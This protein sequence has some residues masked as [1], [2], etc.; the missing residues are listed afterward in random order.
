[1]TVD[2]SSIL[3]E[4]GKKIDI[5]CNIYPNE[6]EFLGGKYEFTSPIAVSGSIRNNGES[7]T[8]AAGCASTF[9]TQ[10]ARCG[11]ETSASL[12]FIVDENLVQ[13]DG[14]DHMGEDV[15]LFQGYSVE[16]DDIVMNG[17]FMNEN[18]KHLCSEDCEGLC[19][20]CGCNL[21]ESKCDCENEDIDPRW[22]ALL[23]IMKKED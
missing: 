9:N 13:D 22:S 8:F 5:D 3:K 7:L 15:I 12:E 1:M 17:F 21:N 19:P 2:I 10:C 11:G 4:I 23:D 18:G 16:I 14:E 6:T 20:K